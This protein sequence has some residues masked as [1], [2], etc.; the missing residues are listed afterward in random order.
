MWSVWPPT[1]G[2]VLWPA[3]KILEVTS[4]HLTCW[5]EVPMGCWRYHW[6]INMWW[7]PYWLSRRFPLLDSSFILGI[8][9]PCDLVRND[10][11][12]GVGLNWLKQMRILTPPGYSNWSGKGTWPK[13]G[14]PELM[15]LNSGSFLWANWEAS[16]LFL[17]NHKWEKQA[18][19]GAPGSHLVTHHRKQSQENARTYGLGNSCWIKPCLKLLLV[20]GFWAM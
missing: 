2:V 7:E 12:L 16:A 11:I 9:Q 10:P 8:S 17:A 4:V 3:H 13:S 1:D 19:L 15:S 18:V 6:L 5:S 20:L 14:Q